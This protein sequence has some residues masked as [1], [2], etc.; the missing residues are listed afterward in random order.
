MNDI[1]FG[2]SL[3]AELGGRCC[4]A[5]LRG[6]CCITCSSDFVVCVWQSIN[7]ALL[8]ETYSV[9]DL[10]GE[11]IDFFNQMNPTTYINGDTS[12]LLFANK[13]MYILAWL[14]F[15]VPT[16][17]LRQISQFDPYQVRVSLRLVRIFSSAQSF[18]F[19]HP[20]FPFGRPSWPIEI[21]L[22]H[23]CKPLL[24]GTNERRPWKRA[25]EWVLQKRLGKCNRKV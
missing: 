16:P 20:L 14:R 7:G 25:V 13:R 4:C 8:K 21:V 22:R 24:W 10:H 19:P 5:S 23:P 1:G 9:S 15:S 12:M 6:D 17:E 3:T 11:L 2:G 18:V